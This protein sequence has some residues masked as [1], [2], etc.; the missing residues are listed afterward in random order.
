M[1]VWL[2]DLIF[3]GPIFGYSGLQELDGNRSCCGK[4]RDYVGGETEKTASDPPPVID[5]FLEVA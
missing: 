2:F 4:F 5:G 3:G 1:G